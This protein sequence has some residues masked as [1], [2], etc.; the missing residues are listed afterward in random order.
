MKNDGE[1]RKDR[2]R[3]EIPDSE[4]EDKIMKN[5]LQK[6]NNGMSLFDVF[7][8]DFFKPMF[9]DER[10]DLKTNIKETDDGYEL[11]V[12]IPGYKKDEIK[13]SLENGYLTVSCAKESKEEE[14]GKNSRYVR[15]EISESCQRSYYVGNDITQ[16]QIKAKYDNGILSL[17]VP[18]EQPKLAKNNYI[19][20]E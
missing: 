2:Y 10:Q 1:V 9:L 15:K 3:S 17:T 13:V 16:E 8:D 12:E 14:K 6:R 18:K 4:K 20:I 11:E 19:A 5:Y 7:D